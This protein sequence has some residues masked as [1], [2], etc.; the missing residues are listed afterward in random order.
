[1]MLDPKI[2]PTDEKLKQDALSLVSIDVKFNWDV[3]LLDVMGHS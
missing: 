2:M 1:M 3:M